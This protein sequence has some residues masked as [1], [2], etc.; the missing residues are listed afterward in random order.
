MNNYLNVL[1]L[2]KCS[3]LVS[4]SVILYS[5]IE[6]KRSMYI[7]TPSDLYAQGTC[8]DFPW[9]AGLLANAVTCCINQKTP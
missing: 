7:L 8:Q 3:H 1:Q 2:F 5:L 6:I 4:N 9:F